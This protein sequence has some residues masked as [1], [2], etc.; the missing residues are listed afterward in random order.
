MSSAALSTGPCTVTCVWDVV[1]VSWHVYLPLSEV[2]TGEK[3]RVAPPVE[4]RSGE[5][6]TAV[7]STIQVTAVCG[8][9]STDGLRV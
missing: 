9:V 7:P 8:L 1:T 4:I 5:V 3:L 6:S 2:A